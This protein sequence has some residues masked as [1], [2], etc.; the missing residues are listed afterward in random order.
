MPSKWITIV[1]RQRSRVSDA[2]CTIPVEHIVGVY[3][4][5]TGYYD[6]PT[7]SKE[8]HTT[9]YYVNEHSGL[10]NEYGQASRIVEK[11]PDQ[12]PDEALVFA[13]S[14]TTV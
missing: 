5:D 10:P 9:L 8:Y 12:T 11:N 3:S 4:P 6:T 13:I 7:H 2:Q 14:R 1:L